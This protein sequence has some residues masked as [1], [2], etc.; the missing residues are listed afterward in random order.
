MEERFRDRSHQTTVEIILRSFRAIHGKDLLPMEQMATGE[1]AAR[2]LFLCSKV[3]LAHDR[4]VVNVR[5][6]GSAKRRGR[7]DHVVSKA[8][9]RRRFNVRL[10][11]VFCHVSSPYLFPARIDTTI[12]TSTPISWGS[13]HSKPIG[14]LSLGLHPPPAPP[15]IPPLK[16]TETHSSVKRSFTDHSPSK[17]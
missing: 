12:V 1:M 17:P 7:N 11:G 4:V 6:I 3:V 8:R 13:V 16:K 10:G 2:A 5:R 9:T 15:T 14:T